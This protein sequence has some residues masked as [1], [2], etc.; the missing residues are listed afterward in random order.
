LKEIAEGATTEEDIP[1]ALRSRPVLNQFQLYYWNSFQEISGSRQFTASGVADIPYPTKLT[2]LN[3]NEVDDPDD[4]RD[5]LQMI[6][7][8]DSIYT[9]HF[10]EKSKV[11]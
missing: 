7:L 4:R 3:E 5:C 8:L 9:E 10:Y 1:H 2:W 11:K 6:G